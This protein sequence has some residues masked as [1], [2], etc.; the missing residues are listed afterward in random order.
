MAVRRYTPI[1]PRVL[2]E[3]QTEW[4]LC[5]SEMYG[6]P[7]PIVYNRTMRCAKGCPY[8]ELCAGRL[9]GQDVEAIKAYR[10]AKKGV[11]LE[12]SEEVEHV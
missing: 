2:E 10:Y 1:D 11:E 7:L 3:T 6:T 9:M 12:V 5:V 8:Y 4:E